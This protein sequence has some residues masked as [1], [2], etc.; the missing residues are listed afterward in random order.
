MGNNIEKIREENY[1]NTG[2]FY[3]KLI[4]SK[5]LQNL[6]LLEETEAGNLGWLYRKLEVSWLILKK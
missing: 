4:E 5:C 3:T 1:K 6:D 2:K